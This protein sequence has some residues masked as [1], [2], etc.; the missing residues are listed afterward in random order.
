MT[1]VVFAP[2]GHR[3]RGDPENAAGKTMMRRLRGALIRVV[4]YVPSHLPRHRG[5]ARDAAPRPSKVGGFSR[6]RRLT[7][8][9]GRTGTGGANGCPR[10][11]AQSP[12][13]W[14]PARMLPRPR[15]G[16]RG[17]AS[18]LHSWGSMLAVGSVG[19]GVVGDP[20][21]CRGQAVPDPPARPGQQSSPRD[22][23]RDTRIIDTSGQHRS[24]RHSLSSEGTRAPR[25]A[26]RASHPPPTF[27]EDERSRL[28]RP[29]AAG[30][31]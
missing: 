5:A 26:A 22:D 25:R 11:R 27:G 9:P 2:H 3:P 29:A 6:R 18:P 8:R 24:A 10:W 21:C 14:L 1:P 7:R 19:Q 4:R 13:G 23:D 20:P 28:S 17:S 30:A 16:G 15:R 31:Y 12:P